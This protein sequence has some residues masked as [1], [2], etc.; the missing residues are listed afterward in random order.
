MVSRRVILSFLFI[1][2]LIV[3]SGCSDSSEPAAGNGESSGTID[4][5]TG[6]FV[7]KSVDVPLPGGGF[8]PVELIGTDLMLDDDGEHIDLTVAVR[9]AGRVPL[10]PLALWLEEFTPPS[11]IVVNADSTKPPFG[12][13][14]P[15]P[16]YAFAFVYDDEFGSDRVLDPGEISASRLWR[17]GTLDQ[18]P[19]SFALRVVPASEPTESAIS[20]DC[21]WDENRNG[22]KDEGE[23]PLPGFVVVIAP[24]GTRTTMQ[25]DRS[26]HYAYQLHTTGLHEVSFDP[27]VYTLDGGDDDPYPFAPIAYSTPNPRHVLITPGP[28]GLP[29][30]FHDAHFGAYTDLPP[31]LPVIRFTDAPP[32]SLHLE[33]WHLMEVVVTEDD[34][35]GVAVGYSG[36]QPEHRFSLWMSGGFMESFP[37][38]ANIVLVHETA[39]ECDAAFQN[40]YLFDLAP[41]AA[42]FRE[43]YGRGVLILNFIDF[44]GEAHRLTW[45]IEDIYPPD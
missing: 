21:F 35:L 33:P 20:G 23:G 42:S 19:F 29:R 25:T 2:A 22:V 17:F 14:L 6:T 37:V 4:P 11:T 36:C 45:E 40:E 10:S 30:G 24:D 16:P 32:N 5:G 12:S 44:Q 8:V 38:Q 34:R 43:A 31:P 28:D 13:M 7:L 26:G 15:I 3:F 27:L 41:L 9:N 39:E 1:V 18:T